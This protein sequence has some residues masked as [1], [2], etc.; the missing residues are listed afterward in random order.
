MTTFEAFDIASCNKARMLNLHKLHQ[1]LVNDQLSADEAFRITS[2]YQKYKDL[3]AVSYKSFVKMCIDDPSRL[4][5]LEK[6]PERSTTKTARMI[7]YYNSK[8]N[9]KPQLVPNSSV[10]IDAINGM[11]KNIK[12][13]AVGSLIADAVCKSDI[14]FFYHASQIKK[15]WRQWDVV[16][17]F[18]SGPYTIHIVIVG[19]VSGNLMKTIT[20]YCPRVALEYVA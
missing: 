19:S 18:V 5:G 16:N 3:W 15:S 10:C 11:I 9:E 14:Y 13:A 4:A 8:N 1:N 2:H 6:S 17:K 12:M 7:E 20:K